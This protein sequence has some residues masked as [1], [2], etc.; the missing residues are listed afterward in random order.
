LESKKGL[1]VV[2]TYN[3]VKE[4]MMQRFAQD[5]THSTAEDK[6]DMLTTDGF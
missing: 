4:M 6:P 3:F 1:R 2:I 5:L